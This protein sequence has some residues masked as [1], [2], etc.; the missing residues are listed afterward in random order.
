MDRL[1]V[2]LPPAGV[3]TC[4][5]VIAIADHPLCHPDH[6]LAVGLAREMFLNVH[7]T[8]SRHQI[9]RHIPFGSPALWNALY[10]RA[11]APPGSPDQWHL[12]MGGGGDGRPAQLGVQY[13][14]P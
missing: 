14:G 12:G 11:A 4:A 5:A 2:D 7:A 6:A 8:T 13:R 9:S 3:L 1:L 10:G